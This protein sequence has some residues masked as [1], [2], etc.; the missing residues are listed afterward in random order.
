MEKYILV[1]L[2][3]KKSKDLAQVITNETARKILDYLGEKEKASPTEISKHLTIPLPSIT[4]NL[5][6]LEQ[7]G[8]IEKKDFAWSD[9][10]RKVHL[11]A[12][13]K[14][15]I[16]IAPKWF[17][18][19]NTLKKI[20]PV[21]L[22][23]IVVSVALRWY[24]LSRIPAMASEEALGVALPATKGLSTTLSNYYWLYAVVATVALILTIIA[25]QIWRRK[26]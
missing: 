6:H 14:K 3:E 8:L 1:S 9:K 22:G 17:D 13:A 23:G 26:Q 25:I 15:L 18:W 2:D 24:E 4:Y 21:A 16:I 11:Y 10:G 19:Q 12:I 20:L 7:Q 5:Q